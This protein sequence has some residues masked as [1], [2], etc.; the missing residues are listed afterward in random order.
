MQRP[1]SEAS[2]IKAIGSDRFAYERVLRLVQ[3]SIGGQSF[4]ATYN[5]SGFLTGMAKDGAW[6][7]FTPAAVGGNHGR[8]AMARKALGEPSGPESAGSPAEPGS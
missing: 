2:N 3:A 8:R 1:F 4:Q 6:Q 7:T 5:A